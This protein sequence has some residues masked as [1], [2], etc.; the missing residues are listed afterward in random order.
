[1]AW[2]TMLING[3]KENKATHKQIRKGKKG[4][5]VDKEN[6]TTLT[7]EGYMV[8]FGAAVIQKMQATWHHLEHL[9]KI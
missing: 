2:A 7:R 5:R 3:G 1:M 6:R 9:L 8:Q 4:I